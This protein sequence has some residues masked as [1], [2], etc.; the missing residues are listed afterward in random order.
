M[1][2]VVLFQDAKS[3]GGENNCNRYMVSH[4][5]PMGIHTIRCLN[6]GGHLNI[7][8]LYGLKIFD[9]SGMPGLDE[10]YERSIPWSSAD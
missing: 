6:Y 7:S 4:I 3:D 5:V 2:E 10:I 8:L 9:H 1:R